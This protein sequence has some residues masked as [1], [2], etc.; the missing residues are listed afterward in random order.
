MG[1]PAVGDKKAWAAVL[2]KGIK[3][4]HDNAINGINGMPPRGGTSLDDAKIK[5]IT[6]YMISQSK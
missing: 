1:A 5:E 2:E 3:A 6:D 4:V